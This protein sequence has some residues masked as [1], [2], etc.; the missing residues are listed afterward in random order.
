MTGSYCAALQ[1]VS[2][3]LATAKQWEWWLATFVADA[4][5]LALKKQHILALEQLLEALVNSLKC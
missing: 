5:I 1:S 2:C 4:G 3:V